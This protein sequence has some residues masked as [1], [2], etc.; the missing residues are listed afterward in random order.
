MEKLID[1]KTIAE[2]FGMDDLYDMSSMSNDSEK[3]II[4]ESSEDIL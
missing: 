1:G 2:M 3:E 4:E